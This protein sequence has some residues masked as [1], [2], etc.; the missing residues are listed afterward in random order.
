M[1]TFNK[2]EAEGILKDHPVVKE[3]RET[4][5]TMSKGS[6]AYLVG[7][8]VVDILE[9][10]KPKDY[11]FNVSF[12]EEGWVKI[13]N[14]PDFRFLYNSAT[15]TTYLFKGKHIVQ[16]LEKQSDH[17]PFFIEKI[18]YDVVKETIYTLNSF[19][20]VSFNSKRLIPYRAI[21]R[22]GSITHKAYKQRVKRWKQKGYRIPNIT[23][24]S[25]N[26]M[27]TGKSLFIKLKEVIEEYFEKE[28]S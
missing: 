3:L 9:G 25:F 21:F 1:K 14:N 24:K 6:H 2:K 26:K 15:A 13:N 22:E 16:I 11:D 18:K 17:F 19:T 10:R 28:E 27:T 8:A 4:I 23:Y 7:G 12:C 5:L 20:E